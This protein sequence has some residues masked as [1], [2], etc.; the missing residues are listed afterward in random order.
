MIEIQSFDFKFTYD[1]ALTM[2]VLAN[3]PEHKRFHI[4]NMTIYRRDTCIKFTS[5]LLNYKT[6]S[7]G[8]G[9]IHI[10]GFCW[11]NSKCD[12]L[13]NNWHNN[14]NRC[15]NLPCGKTFMKYLDNDWLEELHGKCY[16]IMTN[17]ILYNIGL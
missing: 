14:Y 10:P 11:E 5:F 13:R 4:K 6:N 17:Y 7:C 3:F 2:R 8:D 12:K 9:V 16:Q 1:N 15:R